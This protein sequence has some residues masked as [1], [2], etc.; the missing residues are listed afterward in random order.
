MEQKHLQGA[1]LFALIW[2]LKFYSSE[3]D[4]AGS[5]GSCQVIHSQVHVCAQTHAHTHNRV[6]VEQVVGWSSFCPQYPA[7]TQHTPTE[8]HPGL[9]LKAS[10]KICFCDLAP[11][12]LISAVRA[13]TKLL[14]K[15]L[16]LPKICQYSYDHIQIKWVM[17]SAYEL[18]TSHKSGKIYQQQSRHILQRANYIYEL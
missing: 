15:Y 9:Y 11:L 2:S 7:P 4:S 1:N 12:N 6:S 13:N 16:N 17:L 14:I 10:S 3:K 18:M 8:L 5:I